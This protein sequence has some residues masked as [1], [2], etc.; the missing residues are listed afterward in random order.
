[1]T[2]VQQRP[3]PDGSDVTCFSHQ[4][5]HCRKTVAVLLIPFVILLICATC[6]DVSTEAALTPLLDLCVDIYLLYAV[7]VSLVCFSTVA[8]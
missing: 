8:P 1:M 6:R 3:V 5:P 7:H 4:A 2:P